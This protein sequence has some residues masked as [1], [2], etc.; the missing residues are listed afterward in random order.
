LDGA[1]RIKDLVQ[2]ARSFDMPALAITDHGNMYGAV[3]F[4]KACKKENIK[5]IIGCE[6]YYATDSRHNKSDRRHLILLSKNE[7]GYHN[8]IKLVSRAYTEG[9]YY[10]P[11]I[12][13][14]LLQQYHEGLIA[15]TACMGG[16][17]PKLILGNKI[18]EAERMSL[19]FKEL[20]KEDFYL[21]LMDH[22][23]KEESIINKEL[24][25]ISNK[26]N[27][28]LVATNDTHYINQEDAYIQEVLLCIS[29]KNS[30]SNPGRFRFPNNE[31][32][33]KSPEQM[34]SIFSAVPEA[35]SNTHKIAEKC[36]LEIKIDQILLPKFPV[37]DAVKYLRFLVYKNLPTRLPRRGSE[38]MAR[39]NYE[40]N[41]IN[42][43][44]F[45]DYFLITHDIIA[46][47]KSQNIPMGPGR[48]S[49]AGSIVAYILGITEI[50]PL[51]YGLLFERFL[52]PSRISMPDIDVDCCYRRRNE[53][54]NYITEKYGKDYV[55]QIITF[56]T[57]AAKLAIRDVGRVLDEPLPA[58]DSLAKK[59]SDLK[60][61]SE[62]GM[63][64]V[65]NIARKV[66]NMPRHTGVHAAGII[67]GAS[68]ITD[69]VPVQVNDGVITTQYE[70]G[71]CEE[72]GL[73]KMDIL[74]LKTLTIIDDALKLIQKKGVNIDI[75]NP[76]LN[77][78][79]VY[80]LLSRGETSGVFQLESEG[81]RRILR[82][83]KPD[84]FE[85]LIAMVALY[86]PGPLGSGMVDDYIDRKHGISEIEYPHP[87]LESI[88]KETYGVLL[89]QEQIMQIAVT[90]SGFSLP[91]ADTLRKAVGKKKPELLKAQK[92]KFISG[93]VKN[94]YNESKASE[95]FDLIDYFSGYGFNKSH[96]AAYAF[97]A[98]QTAYL[99]AHHPAEFMAALMSNTYN[100]D[101]I[102]LY[103]NE[104][105]SLG[106]QILPPDI[107]LSGREF[108]L[109]DC[110]IRFG[111]GAI[112]NLG[113]AIIS[114]ILTNRPFK[115]LFDLVYKAH[116]NKAALETLA[117]S[118]ALSCFGNRRTIID[119]LPIIMQV[120][121]Q[122]D[123]DEMTLF[124]SV[125]EM[126]PEIHQK[127]EYPLDKVLQ[128]EKE[129]LGFYISSHPLDAYEIPDHDSIA[130]LKE[131]SAAIVGLVVKCKSGN[132]DGKPWTSAVVEDYT[133]LIDVLIFG[134]S[135]T[136]KKNKAYFFR[137]K[138]STEEDKPKMFA[139]L[140][141]EISKKTA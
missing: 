28:P 24:I 29:T 136:L 82:K 59:A 87:A 47:A 104:C 2:K 51:D 91:E 42:N 120:T 48:G 1:S 116:L 35:I 84:C 22:G 127:K 100:Q 9:F 26:F 117:Y 96:S 140:T 103:V 46:W 89:Y 54:I 34:K 23:L 76:P 16:E 10:K 130:D 20:F 124:G 94:G 88:L 110:K 79:K 7:T 137:G 52:N 64:H 32:Y 106:I 114:Q 12:D 68:P 126:L 90:M 131:G 18:A 118:G 108:K 8:L 113:D 41:V 69:T 141:K 21:E 92:E 123:R 25:R 14:E 63:E 74:G 61:L 62:P 53:V 97:I 6:V 102:T 17:I 139:Y 4:Y 134:K 27:I 119:A 85:D 135:I 83:L 36:N 13:W 129:Y 71:T 77:D 70:M 78:R 11:R 109:D 81:M 80:Q 122:G 115:D 55:A 95:I 125:N 58:I 93:A 15:M 112:K 49:A 86:R 107:N 57:M 56:D 132:K 3:E 5:P 105:R 98:F 75:N 44:G 38:E 72:I 45:A 128:L 60:K 31:F 40:L 30:M 39:I 65:I 43:M 99:K 111:L 19:E 73:L 33:F 138:I 133:G 37:E 50:N 101:K 66:E 121:S 67:I